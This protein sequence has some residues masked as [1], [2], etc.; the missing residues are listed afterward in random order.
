MSP[1]CVGTISGQGAQGALTASLAAYSG[2]NPDNTDI[3]AVDLS[4]SAGVLQ[5]VPAGSAAQGLS[6][7]YVD[8]ELLAYQN[9]AL[10]TANVFKFTLPTNTS[11]IG[12]TVYFKFQSFNIYGSATQDISTCTAFLYTVTGLGSQVPFTIQASAAGTLSANQSVLR[13]I[14]AE[15]FFIPAGLTGTVVSEGTAATSMATFTIAKNGTSFGT[16]AIAPTGA[17]TLTAASQ[18]NF[19]AWDVL[20]LT[21]PTTSDPTL[22]N[23]AFG[24]G[25][26]KM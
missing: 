7:C 24:I 5:P 14:A 2:A 18:T 17:V 10:T 15:N 23:V 19:I 11:L 4:E 12:Q 22:A 20:T 21:T 16:I 25:A 8:G 6:L 9:E 1:F 26:V 13:Y 3:L